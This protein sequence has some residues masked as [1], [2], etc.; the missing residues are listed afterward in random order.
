MQV[1]NSFNKKCKENPLVTVSLEDAERERKGHGSFA[2][3]CMCDCQW[4]VE[5]EEG[6]ENNRK[7]SY[8]ELH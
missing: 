6:R 1:N 2:C 8:W 5:D 3:A 4:E 7:S